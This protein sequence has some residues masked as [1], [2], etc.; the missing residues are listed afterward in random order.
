[1]GLSIKP[2]DQYV[3]LRYR[4]PYAP[5]A[6]V[7]EAIEVLMPSVTKQDYQESSDHLIGTFSNDVI[8]M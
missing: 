4:P 2:G 3:R 5:W 7:S 8:L 6:Y 1:M